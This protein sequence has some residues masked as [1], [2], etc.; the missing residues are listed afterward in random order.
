M[1]MNSSLNVNLSTQLGTMDATAAALPDIDDYGC[2]NL[3]CT[4]M[5]FTQFI[6][7]PQTLP[8]HKALLISIIF[9]GIF[10]TGVLG[11]VL[12]CMVIIRHAAMHTA[13]NYYLFSLAVSDL[14]YLLLGLPTEVFLYW[15]QYPFLFGLQ[16]CKLRAFVSEACTYV[17][18]FTIVAFSM[19]RFL[20]ICYP[21]HV[22]AMSGFQRALRII[23]VLWIVSFLTAIPF[24]VKTEIQYLNYPIDGSRILES[25]FCSME[26]EFPDKYPLF[27]GSFIIFFIIPMILIFVLYGRMGAQI[28]SRAADQLGVQQ[29]SRNRESRSSQKK[30]RAVIR[31]LA[32]VVITFFVCWFPF[33]LQR[34][35]FLYAKNFACFQN[36]N[37][38]LF[39]IAGFAYYVSCTIN[40]IVYN[41]MSKR[42]R[43]AFKEILCGKKAGAFYNSGFARDQSSFMRDETSFRRNGSTNN[44]NLSSSNVRY[45]RNRVSDC[46]LLSTT[47]I[48]IVLGNRREANHN[49]PEETDIKKEEP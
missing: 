27:E 28:R 1:N 22:C 15:H 23:T 29:G 43:I 40:P 13:T 41:V 25:A 35:W 19:E 49:I 24:G 9:S 3:N 39:S 34:L 37:E 7:G 21:L 2:P 47:K 18:V 10:I 45:N 11:N 16:F 44:N 46:S 5:E 26:S 20:A 30:K 32:A 38:W 42:Y 17:S 48:V 12:V 6:L 8:L 36:V 14:L 33:H 31:M 4:P